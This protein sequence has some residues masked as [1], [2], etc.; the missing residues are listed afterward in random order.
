[1]ETPAPPVNGKERYEQTVPSRYPSGRA[2]S[3]S[4]RFAVFQPAGEAVSRKEPMMLKRLFL[5]AVMMAVALVSFSGLA[6]CSD[7]ADTAEE[8]SSETVTEET[9][10]DKDVYTLKVYMDDTLMASFVLNDLLAL[11][12]VVLTTPEQDSDQQGPTLLSVLHEAG[13]DT[14]HE[15]TIL[16]LTQGR[17]AT[18]ELVLTSNQIDET[19]VLDITNRGTTKLAGSNL[20]SDKWIRDVSELRLK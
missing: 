1:M 7:D 10:A 19:V 20:S 11:E 6:G 13:I 4:L 16:G 18:A 8:D 3:F 12:Q 14:F 15:I 17:L 5:I 2:P 9:A